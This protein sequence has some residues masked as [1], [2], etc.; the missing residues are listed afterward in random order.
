VIV[1]EWNSE[2]STLTPV[3]IKDHGSSALSVSW[4]PDGR[5]LAVAGGNFD[6]Y[7]HIWQ[8]KNYE[9]VTLDLQ[10]SGHEIA[11]HPNSRI[12]ATGNKKGQVAVWKLT[13]DPFSL[14]PDEITLEALVQLKKENANS[15]QSTMHAMD[16]LGKL[17]AK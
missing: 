10:Y 1:Y 6:S 3:V 2:T 12:F 11:F 14:W 15:D 9:P 4:S 13:S 5:Y 16:V 7:A 8:T 17:I